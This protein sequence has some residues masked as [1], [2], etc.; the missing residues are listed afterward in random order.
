MIVQ[1]ES[2]YFGNDFSEV[3]LNPSYFVEDNYKAIQ[4]WSVGN[5][6]KFAIDRTY[7]NM[8]DW[9]ETFHFGDV[10]VD[11]INRR[12]RYLVTYDEK[13]DEWIIVNEKRL[14][15]VAVNEKYGPLTVS[16]MPVAR[17][18]NATDAIKAMN[19]YN[20]VGYHLKSAYLLRQL[21]VSYIQKENG[22][23]ET[24]LGMMSIY[25]LSTMPEFQEINMKAISYGTE[26]LARNIPYDFRVELQ[27][28][29]VDKP[30]S[31]LGLYSQLYDAFVKFDFFKIKKYTEPQPDE[32]DIETE[33]TAFMNI[34]NKYIHHS[35]DTRIDNL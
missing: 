24:I 13:L 26:N 35:L 1:K 32:L 9:N 14:P 25:S 8:H 2:E 11:I 10:P 34:I 31:L 21:I 12:N 6:D 22:L 4:P 16:I 27:H 28:A 20:R 7:V 3:D 17:Y 30:D 29:K 23:N 19:A 33:T 15:R 18:K 5:G